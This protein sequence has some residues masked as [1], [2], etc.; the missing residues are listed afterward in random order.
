M[1]G[2]ENKDFAYF[3]LTSSR[4]QK[5]KPIKIKWTRASTSSATAASSKRRLCIS[6]S[7]KN[8]SQSLINVSSLHRLAL[9][10]FITNKEQ[11]TINNEQQTSKKQ[12]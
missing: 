7:L 5:A 8:N 1:H 6:L 4:F 2:A 3:L 11:Q 12:G 10:N 9:S